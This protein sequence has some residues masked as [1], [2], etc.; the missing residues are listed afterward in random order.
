MNNKNIHAYLIRMLQCEAAEQKNQILRLKS[1]L[2]EK[3]AVLSF[4][5][6]RLL[7]RIIP[8]FLRLRLEEFYWTATRAIGLAYL[9][10]GSRPSPSAPSLSVRPRRPEYEGTPRP[11]TTPRV[12]IDVTATYRNGHKNGIQ[13]VVRNIARSSIE[14]GLGLPVI[15]DDGR[16]ISFFTH[17]AL[18]DVVEIEEGDRLLLIDSTDASTLAPIMEEISR[19]RGKNIV[20]VYDLIPLLLPGACDFEH[21]PNFRAW[22]ETMTR[23]ADL[24]L[25]ISRSVADDV[26]R[27]VDDNR[28]PTK[29]DLFIGW[30]HLGADL[31][32]VIGGPDPK[33][34]KLAAEGPFFL[35]VG[36]LEPRKGHAIAIDAWEKLWSEGCAARYVI[37]GRRGWN[38]EALRRRIREHPE[39]GRR[40]VWEDQASDADLQHLYRNATALVFPSIAEGF[41]LPLIEAARFGVPVIASDIPAFR[42]ICGDGAVYFDIADPECLARRIRTGITGKMPAPTYPI[43]G[44]KEATAQILRLAREDAELNER[45]RSLRQDA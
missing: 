10:D 4:L 6:E 40:L 45:W 26:E 3:N 29:R 37:A 41:G 5:A 15:I 33:I 13:R 32:E 2:A 27:Y 16:L 30:F 39:F 18:P 14:L 11:Q 12:L 7:R 20:V 8:Q 9:H 43:L 22:F 25:T 21:I 17:E 19:K 1:Q 38:V 23:R 24:I 34:L 44:W 35:T 28:L 31:D 36:T 42:E